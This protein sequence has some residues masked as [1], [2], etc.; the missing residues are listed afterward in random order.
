MRP[1]ALFDMDGTLADYEWSLT[2]KLREMMG[3]DEP[4]IDG[5]NLWEMDKLPHIA[6]RIDAIKN[7]PGWWRDLPRMRWGFDVFEVACR[8]GF[9][10]HILTKGPAMNANAWKEKME[11]VRREL[12]DDIQVHITSD[13]SLVYGAVLVDDYATYMNEW[14]KFRP[15][16]LGVVPYDTDNPNLVSYQDGMDEVTKRLE[17]AYTRKG[18]ES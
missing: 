6:A 15:R 13:K 9:E 18:V 7:V 11:W 2:S 10:P 17:A 16:G 5:A 14:L 1:V 4:S 3:P 8:I 12:G